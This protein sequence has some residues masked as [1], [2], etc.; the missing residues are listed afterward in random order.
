M[1]AVANSPDQQLRLLSPQQGTYSI[2]CASEGFGTHRIDELNLVADAEIVLDFP[3]G[4]QASIVGDFAFAPNGSSTS[5]V[6]AFAQ[7]EASSAPGARTFGRVHAGQFAIDGLAAGTYDIVIGATGHE[8]ARVS[9]VVVSSGDTVDLGAVTLVAS[10]TARLSGQ[11]LSANLDYFARDAVVG[12][13][14]DS[15][16]ITATF[17][18]ADGTF[19]LESLPGGTYTLRVADVPYGIAEETYAGLTAGASGRGEA[20]GYLGSID[21]TTDGTGEA[22]ID[23]SLPSLSSSGEWMTATATDAAGN[24]SEFSLAIPVNEFPWQNPVNTFDV[25]ADGGVAPLDVLIVINF[26]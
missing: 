11:V 23:A 8:D 2:S 15:E 1:A 24:T 20:T 25:N 6:W 16:M 17:A 21:V 18:E 10:P 22:F 4:F 12:L 5:E 14:R 9:G 13:F 19:A 3:L 26:Y 7:S